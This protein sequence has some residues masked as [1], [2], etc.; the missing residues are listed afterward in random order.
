MWLEWKQQ[1]Q[2]SARM[3]A[4]AL[5]SASHALREM[6]RPFNWTASD[7]N[8]KSKTK[9]NLK[10]DNNEDSD[11]ELLQVELGDENSRVTFCL[12]QVATSIFVLLNR[13]VY[14]FSYYHMIVVSFISFICLLGEGGEECTSP[15]LSLSS[16]SRLHPHFHFCLWTRSIARYPAPRN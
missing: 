12:N 9:I 2:P 7:E 3:L 16:T 4:A 14:C 1:A 10:N 8:K 11:K 5:A 13:L 6:W 15:P